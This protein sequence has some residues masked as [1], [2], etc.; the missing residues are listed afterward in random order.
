M[1]LAESQSIPKIT[2][3][4][5]RGRQIRFTLYLCPSTSTGH[6][7]HKDDVVTN[8]DARVDTASSHYSSHTGRPRRFTQLSDTKEC[9][10]P[11]SYNTQQDTRVI[12]QQPITKL[13]EPVASA[14][15]IAYTLPV[16]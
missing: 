3:K 16:A 11:E 8:P 2:S 12:K 15:V 1:W 4:S 10:A 14:P 6:L 13:P 5:Y 7:A 9:V